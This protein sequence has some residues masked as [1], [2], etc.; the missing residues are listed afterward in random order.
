LICI[1]DAL[2]PDRRQ[3]LCF[4]SLV[5]ASG[6]PS[7]HGDLVEFSLFVLT[8]LWS[9]LYPN[10]PF[11]ATYTTPRV[12]VP[13]QPNMYDCGIFLLLNASY[14]S[15]RKQLF[16]D[17]DIPNQYDLSLWYPNQL[18]VSYRNTIMDNLS[19]KP[20]QWVTD[21]AVSLCLT[22]LVGND[23]D[24]IFI[25]P[26]TYTYWKEYAVEDN[27]S[28]WTM[29]LTYEQ[30][31][32]GPKILMVPISQGGH[33]Q[34]LCICNPGSLTDC[35]MFVFD[36][37]ARSGIP[38]NINV[39]RDFAKYLIQTG[40]SNLGPYEPDDQILIHAVTVKVPIQRNGFD[41]GIH[42][43]ANMRKFVSQKAVFLDATVGQTIDGRRWHNEDDVLAL[44]EELWF[45]HMTSVVSL[46]GQTTQ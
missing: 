40:K 2:T 39:L 35:C 8:K 9:T 19:L 46:V 21:N 36:S 17:N 31:F 24:I 15:H 29:F 38:A 44:R 14:L 18:C 1:I 26:S 27:A 43:I 25:P 16:V 10:I 4:D 41:C 42:C 22:Q 13:I 45:A 5:G 11:E 23:S 37:L 34:M 12:F 30:V 32:V 28:Q 7:N 3:I 6:Y 33:W 20:E